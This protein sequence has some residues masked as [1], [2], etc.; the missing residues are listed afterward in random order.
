MKIKKSLRDFLFPFIIGYLLKEII[1]F[2]KERG[3]SYEH[4][5]ARSLF[6]IIICVSALVLLWTNDNIEEIKEVIEQV[7]NRTENLFKEKTAGIVRPA[8]ESSKRVFL[9][10]NN[11]KS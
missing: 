2:V 4:Q 9:E 5:L 10:N 7:E 1:E 11:F 6:F 8:T 3:F